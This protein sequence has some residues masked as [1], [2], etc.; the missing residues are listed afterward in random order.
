M[1]LARGRNRQD[2]SAFYWPGFVDAMATLLLVIIFLLCYLFS[3]MIAFLM[4]TL[5]IH[6]TGV[7]STLMGEVGFADQTG[8]A[9]AYYQDFLA[10]YG[11]HF[12]T[13]QH[14]MLHGIFTSLFMHRLRPKEKDFFI[15]M[16]YKERELKKGIFSLFSKREKCIWAC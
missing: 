2:A 3:L 10:K 1:A 6:Q 4:Q 13:F 16:K 11:N 7:F 5:V 12:R 8:E 15:A 14:G 9:Y